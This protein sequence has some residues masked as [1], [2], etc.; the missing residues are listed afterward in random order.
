M[1]SILGPVTRVSHEYCP[2]ATRK[3]R[4]RVEGKDGSVGTEVKEGKSDLIHYKGE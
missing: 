2:R 3:W 1:G 4:E